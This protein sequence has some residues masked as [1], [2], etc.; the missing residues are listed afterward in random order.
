[1]GAAAAP[2]SA[3]VATVS[4]RTWNPARLGLAAM[5]A[6][7]LAGNVWLASRQLGPGQPGSGSRTQTAAPFAL[8][9]GL[10]RAG[11]SLPRLTLP[12]D[13]AVVHLRLELAADEY[14]AYRAALLD[15]TGAEA[16]SVSNLTAHEERDATAVVLIVPAA[17]LPSGDHRVKLSGVSSKGEVEG[18][19]TYPFRIASR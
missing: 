8:A 5:L 7:S 2:V 19:A 11:G 13:V 4:R 18:I 16:W 14:P 6:A 9:P 10:L 12:A 15:E 1:V 3:P 17:L